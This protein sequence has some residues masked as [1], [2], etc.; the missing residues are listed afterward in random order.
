MKLT[1]E[2]QKIC[3]KYRKR[4]ENNTVHC[5]DCPL[6]IDRRLCTCKANVTEEEYKEWRGE[7]DECTD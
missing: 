1:E 3:E 5:F 4:D 6:V 2:E 7:E